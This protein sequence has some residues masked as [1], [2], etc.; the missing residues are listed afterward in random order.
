MQTLAFR[1][2]I[3]STCS[4]LGVARVGARTAQYGVAAAWQ[5]FYLMPSFTLMRCNPIAGLL[6]CSSARR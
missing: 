2:E 1:L 3:G 5:P 6:A 4:N